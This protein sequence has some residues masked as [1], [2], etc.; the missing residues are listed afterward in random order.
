MG[1]CCLEDCSTL[2]QVR[3]WKAAEMQRECW[4][5]EIGEAVTES[6]KR[7]RGRRRRRKR[8]IVSFG[9]G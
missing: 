9:G 1:E 7:H 2:L 6:E 5:K 8:S 4:G 3:N